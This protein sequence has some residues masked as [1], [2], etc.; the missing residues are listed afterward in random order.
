[1]QTSNFTPSNHLIL[2]PAC[3][4]VQV[5][6]NSIIKAIEDFIFV[7]FVKIKQFIQNKRLSCV[8]QVIIY[9][10]KL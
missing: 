6:V 10:V 3:T 9:I 8:M 2:L 1:M 5:K 4:K 7:N